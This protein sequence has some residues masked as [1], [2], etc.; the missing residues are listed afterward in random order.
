MGRLVLFLALKV[1]DE[2]VAER[3]VAL[4]Q[5]RRFEDGDPDEPDRLTKGLLDRQP[6]A[7]AA[8]Q[9]AGQGATRPVR[10][11]GFETLG[12]QMGQRAARRQQAVDDPI[13]IGM[14]ALR[15]QVAAMSEYRLL[16]A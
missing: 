6:G 5:T 1:R 4:A 14:A 10:V 16:A 15:H 3:T 12:L 13:A 8:G 9:R 7:K 11:L 2:L